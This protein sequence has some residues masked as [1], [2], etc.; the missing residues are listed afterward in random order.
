MLPVFKEDTLNSIETRIA[1]IIRSDGKSWKLSYELIKKV[2]KERLWERAGHRSFT[3]WVRYM[4]NH[5]SISEISIWKIRSAGDAY[6]QYRELTRSKGAAATPLSECRLAI[7]TIISLNRMGQGNREITDLLISY[8][9]K[10]RVSRKNIQDAWAKTR[11]AIESSGSSAVKQ[12][13]YG[14]YRQMPADIQPLEILQET[15]YPSYRS[16]S[17]SD[18]EI[19]H[20]VH[21]Y[22]GANVHRSILENALR[23]YT[24]LM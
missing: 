20:I 9:Q 16:D 18:Q 21:K 24:N 6:E 7:D 4:A 10:H 5:Y 12:N 15:I 13:G 23:E 22:L 8:A 11:K 1:T 17:I 19:L 2:E 3:E 14:S